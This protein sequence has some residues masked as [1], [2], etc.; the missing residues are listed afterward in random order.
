MFTKSELKLIDFVKHTKFLQENTK[1]IYIRRY[2]VIK[3]DIYNKPIDYVIKYPKQFL[4]KLNNYAKKTKGRLGNQ[5]LSLH[6][7]DGYIS[8]IKALFIYN[9]ELK[10]NEKDLLDKWD[11]IHDIIRKPI[12]TKYKSNK[13]T[14]RQEEGYV[15]YNDI[16]KKR[17]ELDDGSIERLLITMYTEIP[18]VRSDFYKTQI[19][20]IDGIKDEKQ[21]KDKITQDINYIIIN[22]EDITK[23]KL[24]LQKY[25][26]SKQYKCI[27]I[28]LNDEILRQLTIS[29]E[30]DPRN[31]LFVGKNK[32]PFDKEN[33]F[34]T[35]ANR[36]IKQKLQN[37]ILT[38]MCRANS[39]TGLKQVLA[40]QLVIGYVDL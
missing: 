14:P 16:L 4:S 11:E 23:S 1:D 10:E 12:D 39:L 2:E 26:T 5:S 30:K 8:A 3:N 15:S 28:P 19:V 18:P 38:N 7:K 31:Y 17:N 27:E 29:L 20:Y 34:N 36:L 32:K 13:P 37:D 33:S 35:F 21:T 25:K 22:K 24:I 6:A 40:F 9:Q